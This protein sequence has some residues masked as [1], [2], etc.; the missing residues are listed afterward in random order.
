MDRR[1]ILRY[2]ALATGAA[3]AFPSSALIFSGCKPDI[4]T[5]KALSFFSNDEI[6]LTKQIIDVI[7]PKTD[8]PSASEVG[9][10]LMIDNMVGKSY[11]EDNKSKYRSAFDALK[12]YLIEQEFDQA[13]DDQRLDILNQLYNNHDIAKPLKDAFLELRQQ[14]IASYLSTEEIGTNYLN[15]LPVPGEYEACIDLASV[16]NK[17]WAI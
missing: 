5:A 16:N 6:E 12:K 9:V 7:L 4:T 15:Y 10:H 14:T 11:D 13:Q 1:D 3:I 2:T 17:A 8:S